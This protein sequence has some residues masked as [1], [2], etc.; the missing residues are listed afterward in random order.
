[1][2]PSRHCRA[3]HLGR[4]GRQSLVPDGLGAR[5]AR[6]ARPLGGNRDWPARSPSPSVPRHDP[7]PP[8]ACSG[9]AL[10][11]AGSEKIEQPPKHLHPGPIELGVADRR[12]FVL[13]EQAWQVFD[14]AMSRPAAEVPL[15]LLPPRPDGDR[16]V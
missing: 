9:H 13:D 11:P 15:S 7:A 16:P 1:M 4:P 2:S 10:H 5:P 6:S 12:V 3:G 8:Q 14:Q